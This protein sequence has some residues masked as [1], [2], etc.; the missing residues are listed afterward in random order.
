MLRVTL[1]LVIS[2]PLRSHVFRCYFVKSLPPLA[3]RW[4]PPRPVESYGISNRYATLCLT[5]A[6][7][8]ERYSPRAAFFGLGC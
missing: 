5:F 4:R 8:I 1:L 6:K 7:N 3:G 2:V